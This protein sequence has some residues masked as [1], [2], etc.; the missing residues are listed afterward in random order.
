MKVAIFSDKYNGPLIGKAA[1][2]LGL[3]PYLFFQKEQ[4][5]S[6]GFI[7]YIANPNEPIEI[8]AESVESAIGGKPD[9]V[10]CCIEQ[11]C[12][13]VAQYADMIGLTVNSIESY[14]ILRN[15]KKMKENWLSNGVTTANAVYCDKFTD[16]PFD[17]LTFPV[18]VKPTLGAASVGVRIC[19]TEEELYKQA[20][21]ILRF[22]ITTLKNE[23]KKSGFLVEEYISGEE[24]SIDTIWYNGLPYLDA[25]MKKGKPMGPLFPDRLYV[26]SDDI[27]DSIREEL[28][29][30]SHKAVLAAKVKSGATHTEVRVK[31]GKGYVI[32]SALRPGAGGCFYSLF[33]ESLGTSFYEA[34]VLTGLPYLSDKQCLYLDNLKFKQRIKPSKIKYW[35]NMGYE[36]SGVIRAINGVE[37]I[38]KLKYVDIIKIHRDPGDF[39]PA[40][41]D[42]F[43]YFGWIMGTLDKD[44]FDENYKLMLE[45]EKKI[46]ILF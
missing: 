41:C 23:N 21:S 44:N 34:L 12:V 2:R 26:M 36:G 9:A 32:E 10:I 19:N 14:E 35:Y 20:N 31:N 40:E 33:E 39:L 5:S 22:N 7:Y 45:T 46:K 27:E 17:K 24:Y 28:L 38:K 1:C 13:K 43:V 11:F 3:T 18:I 42:S 29:R 15:K 30:V 25:I 4:Q 37:D 16:I 6:L 8:L